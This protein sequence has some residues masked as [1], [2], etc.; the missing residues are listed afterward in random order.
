MGVIIGMD[1]DVEVQMAGIGCNLYGWY[2]IGMG[3]PSSLETLNNYDTVIHT[4]LSSYSIK[5]VQADIRTTY[6]SYFH[7][8]LINNWIIIN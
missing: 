3:I 6:V 2:V 4:L 1:M 8:F 7:S 5:Q